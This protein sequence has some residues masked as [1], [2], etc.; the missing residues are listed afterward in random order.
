MQVWTRMNNLSKVPPALSFVKQREYI[1]NACMLFH[2]N[3]SR[4]FIAS[5]LFK[6]L[7]LQ[8][9]ARGGTELTHIINSD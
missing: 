8:A 4:N 3:E 2:F 5:E 9:I 6:I 1:S 7:T